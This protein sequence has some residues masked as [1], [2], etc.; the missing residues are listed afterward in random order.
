MVPV[1]MCLSFLAV[2]VALLFCPFRVKVKIQIE[3]RRPGRDQRQKAE[4]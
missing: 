4:Q 1:S 2:F 3:L